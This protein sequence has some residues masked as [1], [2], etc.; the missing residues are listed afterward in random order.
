MGETND[1]E[2]CTQV[3]RTGAQWVLHGER[4]QSGSRV[5]GGGG[6]RCQEGLHARAA[7]H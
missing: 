3:K 1:E 5:E 2:N 4:A 6:A 7:V